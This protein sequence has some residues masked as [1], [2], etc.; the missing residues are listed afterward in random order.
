MSAN[1]YLALLRNKGFFALLVTQALGAC[2]D[3]IYRMIVSLLVISASSKGGALSV[4][5][6]V[7]IVP[8]LIFSGY[9]GYFA[10]RYSKRYVLIFTKSIEIVAMLLGAII[11]HLEQP[12]LLFSVLFLM[13]TQSTFFSPAKYGILPEM[14]PPEALSKANGLYQL[15]TFV[16]IIIGTAIG[17]L[18]MQLF[19]HNLPLIGLILVGIAVIG[20]LCS[21]VVT[22]VK[23]S[24]SVVRFSS[25]PYMEVYRGWQR[26]LH[27]SEL[28]VIVI[29]VSFFWGLGMAV[30]LAVL[31]LG[32]QVLLLSDG[33]IALLNV[34]LGLGIGVGSIFAGWLS[35]NRIEPGLILVG[36]IGITFG[37]IGVGFAPPSLSQVYI[38]LLI[39]GVS[40][41]FYIVPL[42]ALLQH[43][44]A[45]VEKGRI[46]AS[47][48]FLNSI[49]ML[50]AAGAIW[51]FRDI[52]N[53]NA[54][55]LFVLLGMF[56]FILVS[57]L[58][59]GY[60]AILTHVLAW[61]RGN[62]QHNI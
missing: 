52:F 36:G 59:L 13:A 35:K 37:A 41:G 25:N 30:Q 7:F 49:A 19:R 3:N 40:G 33:A 48:N 34:A 21:L 6:V 22:K 46:I 15:T 58:V 28:A 62:K 11:L 14:L 55:T 10:D 51:L 53:L 42:N 43:R 4:A 61:I 16:A 29:G 38:G 8:G 23:P 27:D 2:N 45:T 31:L 9:A 5:A 44:P 57:L 50:V 20:T 47:T 60:P 54:A 39:L 18:L 56:A 24:G 1:T 12:I 26:I 17:G 32:K